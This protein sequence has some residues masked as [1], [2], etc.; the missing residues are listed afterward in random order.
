MHPGIRSLATIVIATFFCGLQAFAITPFPGGVAM[1]MTLD[2]PAFKTGSPIPKKYSCKGEDL[3]P[4]LHWGA[5]PQATASFAL[6]MDD[7]DAPG[8]TWD[9]WL[10]YNIPPGISSL[11]EGAGSNMPPGI[12]AAKNSWGRNDYGGPCPPS[13]TH[14]YFFKLYALD[15]VL[16]IPRSAGKRELEAAMQGHILD[17]AEIMG[18][19][20]K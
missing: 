2:S 1:A 19:Y 3:S 11:P 15:T 8:R 10:L 20:K 17:T 7:P 12:Q 5:A 14:R 13:G 18:T 9:H 6:I 4:A 16:D